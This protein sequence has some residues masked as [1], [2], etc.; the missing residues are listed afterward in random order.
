MNEGKHLTL[1]VWQARIEGSESRSL[2]L[3]AIVA[4]SVADAI[5]YLDN[6]IIEDDQEVVSITAEHDIIVVLPDDTNADP[7]YIL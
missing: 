4:A 3:R 5:R 7:E 1:K 6:Y 2:G